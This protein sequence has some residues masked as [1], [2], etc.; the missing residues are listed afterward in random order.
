[1]TF[2]NGSTT[3]GTVALSNGSAS[4]AATLTSAGNQIITAAYGGD[5]SDAGS[6]G[7]VN[8]AVESPISFPTPPPGSTTLTGASGSDAS[9]S[10]TIDA[11]AGYSG[12]LFLTCSGL[13]ANASCSF[14]PQI[15]T[16]AASSATYGIDVAL[17]SPAPVMG[18]VNDSA[19]HP[20]AVE[21]CGFSLLGLL[22]IGRIRRSRLG[23][24]CLV[25]AAG[26]FV[27]LTGCGGGSKSTT[28][29]TTGGVTPPG[30]YTFQLNASTSQTNAGPSSSPVSLTYTLIVQ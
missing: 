4:F 28:S 16:I 15:P 23:R 13:P 25:L 19:T 11:I 17:Y 10:V 27:S 12:A 2:S 8:Q 3:L 6:N 26:V 1:M 18:K 24:L 21:W 20:G 14:T 22:L 7:T 5:G 30:T 9:G 29:P